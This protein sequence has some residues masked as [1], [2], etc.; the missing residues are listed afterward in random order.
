MSESLQIEY[1]SSFNDAVIETLAAFA[2]TKGGKVIIGVDNAGHPL[3][4]FSIGEESMQQWVNE[5]K[6]KTQPSIIP[7]IEVISKEGHQVVEMSI[8][9]FPIKPVSFKGRY[10]KRVQN[11]NHHLSINEITNLHLSSL[12]TS[13]D[14]YEYP[15][16]TIADIDIQKV[17]H[18]INRVNESG[19]FYLE[20]KPVEALEKLS[21]IKKGKPT[22]AA[23]LLF[24]KN[25][26]LYNVHVGRFKTPSYIIDDKII[27]GDLFEVVEETM[28]YIIGQIKVAFE[29]TGKKTQREEIFE[30]PIPALRELVLN[31]IVHRD[32]TSP[33]DIQIKIFDN[34]ITIFNPGKLYGNLTIEDLNTDWYQSQTRNKLVAEAFYL[35]KDIEKYG[36][37]YIRVRNEIK[38]Y[39]SMS[40]DYREM[41]NGF[42]VTLSYTNQKI[43]KDVLKDVPIN[44]LKDVPKERRLDLLLSLIKDNNSITLE[45]MAKA[46]GVTIKTIKRDIDKLKADRRIKR[47]GGRKDGFWKILE[48]Y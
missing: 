34:S 38:Q 26:L 28:R 48:S 39:P 22:N 32:Y 11:S 1:K 8:N 20:G 12:Q 24:S 36:S 41:G 33:I 17:E 5:V 44:V 35:T 46:C 23:M 31:A 7:D 6:N 29:I 45:Q 10:F 3:K 47:E 19:R 9:E 14:A 2:N 16:S 42:L 40:F 27:R 43:T 18:F 30:Y 15:D 37:G 4:G 21:L 25:E 13:W